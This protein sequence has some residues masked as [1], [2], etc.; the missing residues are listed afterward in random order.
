M[1]WSPVRICGCVFLNALC[2][3]TLKRVPTCM[4]MTGRTPKGIA[5]SSEPGTLAL[6]AWALY[7]QV[8]VG[9]K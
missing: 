2:M 3:P 4:W 5:L 7:A 9:F 1:W 6:P 8:W